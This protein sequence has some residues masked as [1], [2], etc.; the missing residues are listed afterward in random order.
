MGEYGGEKDE[1]KGFP[2]VREMVFGCSVSSMGIIFLVEHISQ[3]KTEVGIFG[4]DLFPTPV[5]PIG[6]DIKSLVAPVFI[7][8]RC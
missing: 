3:M 5:N 2:F 8:V 1:I 7:Q 4:G 6:N